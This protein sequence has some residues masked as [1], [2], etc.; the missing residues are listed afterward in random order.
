VGA[1][2]IVVCDGDELEAAALKRAASRAG[3]E[4][5]DTA[6]NAIE[7]LRSAEVHQP[8][9]ALVRNE[10][11]GMLGLEAIDDLVRSRP[12]V[13][14]VLVTTDASLGPT[15]MDAGA[16]AVVLRGDVD[17]LESTL[18]ELG[19]WLGGG[20]RRKGGDRRSGVERR[21]LQDWSKVFSER[22]TGD[23]RR[24]GPRREADGRAAGAPIGDQDDPPAI[25]QA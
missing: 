4:I 17:A 3:F 6:A 8:D 11:F 25:P 10:L 9:A 18:A 20:E 2:R 14:V 21:Q 5:V 1:K 12:K 7:L 24:K 15:A 13:E 23:D 16:F 19:E 22:R